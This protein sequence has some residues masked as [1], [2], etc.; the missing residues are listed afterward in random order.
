MGLTTT[1]LGFQ[2]TE[3]TRIGNFVTFAKTFS[4]FTLKCLDLRSAYPGLLTDDLSQVLAA[5]SGTF[6]EG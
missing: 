6:S 4:N 5:I 1:S 2:N 3:N